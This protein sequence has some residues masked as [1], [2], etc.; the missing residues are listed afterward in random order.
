MNHAATD[1]PNAP[2]NRTINLVLAGLALAYFLLEWVPGFAGDYG[3]FIDEFYYVAC[4][5]HLALGY[6]DHPPLSILLLRLV[7]AVMGDSLP[8]LRVLPSLAGATTVLLTGL[9]ARRLGANAF[10]QAMA[11]GAVMVSGIYQV[12]FG[13]YSMNSLSILLWLLCFWILVE[14]ERRGEPRLWILFGAAAGLALENKHTFLLLPLGMAVGL[15]FTRARRHLACRWLWIGCA[16]A[17]ALFLPNL[18]WQ[19][20]HGWPSI[21]FYRNA[22]VYKNV[23]TPPHQVLLQQV[24][25]MNPGSFPIWLAGLFF[26]LVSAKGRPFRHLG[27]IYIVLLALMLIGRKS[28]PDRIAEAYTILLAGGGAYLGALAGSGR[29]RW[30]RPALPAVLLLFGAPLAPLTLPLLPPRAAS[31]YAAALGLVP[32]IEKGKGKQTALP[33]WLADRCGWEKLVDDV[34]AAAGKIDPT[35]RGQAVILAPSYGQAGA[36][37]LLGRG[38]DLPPVYATQNSYFHWGPPPDSVRVAFVLGPFDEELVRH[39]ARDVELAGVHECDWCMPWRNGVPIWLA[40]EPSV[41]LR[42]V[43]PRLKHYE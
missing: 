24:L 10:G 42:E 9:L 12:L 43:W 2:D 1:L 6:V 15:L 35:E 17:V 13:F 34:E 21:E 29:R 14:I 22:D 19:A 27:W 8:A 25:F 11:A 41:P 16:A 23:P 20:T 37:E 31:S 7:R 38:R 39:L 18:L 5:R 40:R 26:F 28:R 33:Q 32:Q 3:Y 36:I 4:T 30:L